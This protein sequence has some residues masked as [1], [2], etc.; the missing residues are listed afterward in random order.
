MIVFSLKF[1]AQRW[2]H[3]RHHMARL[4]PWLGL[5]SGRAILNPV[6]MQ[7][8]FLSS[9]WTKGGSRGGV[10]KYTRPNNGF[11]AQCVLA[12][13]PGHQHP[14]RGGSGLCWYLR[15]LWFL[16]DRLPSSLGSPS[17]QSREASLVY[18]ALLFPCLSLLMASPDAL[19]LPPSCLQ[20]ALTPRE[21][22]ALGI[23]MV[24][25]ESH[26]GAQRHCLIL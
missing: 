19:S 12:S 6:Q 18:A 11:Q 1:P 14:G 8:Q 3:G 7:V 17:T 22:P 23:G 9:P 13:L 5:S 24:T 20:K 25:S 26:G 4:G 21:A 2:A 10:G 16:E 15:P